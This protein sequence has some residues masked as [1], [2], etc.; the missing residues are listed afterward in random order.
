M[1]TN[2]IEQPVN[3][4]IRFLSSES[5]LDAQIIQDVPVSLTF[6]RNSIPKDRLWICQHPREGT[7]IRA[8]TIFAL[9]RSLLAIIF[10]ARNSPRR[11]S[12]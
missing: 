12:T 10:D 1:R 4:E 3:W 7:L 8:R 6:Y 5:I 11:T 2:G 9:P